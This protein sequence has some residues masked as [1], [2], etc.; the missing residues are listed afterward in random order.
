M[1]EIEQ[2]IIHSLITYGKFTY[3]P[4][5]R[6]SARAIA[7]FNDMGVIGIITAPSEAPITA[8]MFRSP[9]MA[10]NPS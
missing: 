7:R 1:T 9:F 3:L 8:H 2:N 6:V 5:D 4:N 10:A